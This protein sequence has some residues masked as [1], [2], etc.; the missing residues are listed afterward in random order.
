MNYVV[1]SN[2]LSENISELR[3][4]THSVDFLDENAYYM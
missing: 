3:E 2:C 1:A 4:E